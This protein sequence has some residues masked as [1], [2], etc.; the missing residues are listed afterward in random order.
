MSIDQ[1]VI[2]VALFRNSVN[3]KVSC[4]TL[5]CRYVNKAHKMGNGNPLSD[6]HI[7]VHVIG[8]FFPIDEVLLTVDRIFVSANKNA[9][10]TN[11]NTIS[12]NR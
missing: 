7:P 6:N 1:N 5:L 2:L 12:D 3:Q 10:N 8:M 11:G 9:D 4:V